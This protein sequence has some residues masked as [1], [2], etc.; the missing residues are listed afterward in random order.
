M[1]E[2]R[3]YFTFNA[4]YIIESLAFH[5]RKTG[6]ELY[7]DILRYMPYKI[8]YLKAEFFRV[9]NRSEFLKLFEDL[10]GHVKLG[11]HPFL[12][13]EIH[14]STSGLVLNSGEL[15]S[16]SE[17]AC[18]LREL[19][20]V[21]KNNILVSLATCYGAYIYGSILP[22]KPSPFYGFIGPW[23]KVTEN[24]ILN[25]FTKF[26][27]FIKETD[28]FEQIDLDAA[29]E[30]LNEENM[31]AKFVLKVSEAVFNRVFA[32]YQKAM[33]EPGAL[34]KRISSLMKDFLKSPILR[35]KFSR[36]ELKKEVVRKVITESESVKEKMKKQFLMLE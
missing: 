2:E 33:R 8:P 31:S 34:Q 13:F 36:S 11:Q 17:V 28:D 20:I 7:E 29:V 4:I 27:E 15:F 1:N 21:T 14:G 24:D 10:Y 3:R 18:K 9:N 25:S 6:Q 12:H 32:E 5:D 19:N 30:K 22:S 16:W 23:E 35:T 26:F